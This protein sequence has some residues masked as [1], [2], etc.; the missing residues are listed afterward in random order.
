MS[1]VRP[2]I[3][4]EGYIHEPTFQPTFQPEPTQ[5]VH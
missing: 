5:K 3:Y 1:E 2:D 4:N